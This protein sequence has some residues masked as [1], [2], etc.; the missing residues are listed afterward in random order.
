MFKKCHFT[1]LI[2]IVVIACTSVSC[3]K[4]TDDKA[5]YINALS[6]IASTYNN[7]ICPKDEA[8]GTRLETVTFKDNTMIYRMSLSDEAIATIDLEEC[9]NNIIQNMSEKL[10]KYLVKGNCNLEY[11]YVS[12]NDSSSI[13]IVPD[14]LGYV[15]DGTK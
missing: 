2:A 15:E 1:A 14:E 7:K 6:E 5:K 9:R 10:K 4:K 12:P 11:R 8:N 13:T 3:V